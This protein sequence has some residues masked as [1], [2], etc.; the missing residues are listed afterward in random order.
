MTIFQVGEERGIPFLAMPLLSGMSLQTRLGRDERL[1]IPEVLRIGREIAEGLDAAHRRKV[2]HRDIKP[3]NV[4]LEGERGRVKILD[5]GL[6][7]ATDEAKRLTQ[8]GAIL[9]T[10]AYMSPEQATGAKHVD[11][12]L[13]LFSLGSVLYRM[14]A[15]RVP[16]AAEGAVQTLVAVVHSDPSPPREVR[17]EIPPALDALILKLLAK[18]PADRPASARAVVPAINCGNCSN[19]AS[20][21]P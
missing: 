2:I 14:A 5:F 1:P 16:F 20:A 13:D 12:R 21:F 8:E 15:G 10:P 3:A 17:P 11:A 7:R 19:S 18:S 6:A 9:G 4:W